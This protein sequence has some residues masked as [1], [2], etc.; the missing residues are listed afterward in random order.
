MTL[1]WADFALM[2]VIVV[3]GVSAGY[4]VLLRKVR[5]IVSES[6]RGLE[7]RLIAL[8]EAISAHEPGMTEPIPSTDTL[9]AKEIEAESIAT[10]QKSRASSRHGARAAQ[11]ERKRRNAPRD[12]G[13]DCGSR[14][15]IAGQQCPRPGCAQNSVEGCGE[16]MDPAGPRHRAIVPQPAPEEMTMNPSRKE[17]MR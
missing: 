9:D 2:V 17:G 3:A 5:H 6:H 12:P 10:L 1:H 8:T 15:R 4:L 13:G 16:S 11:C 7:H 14:G